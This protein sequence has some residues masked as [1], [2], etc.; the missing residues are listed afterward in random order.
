MG[1]SP[2][3]GWPRKDIRN[4]IMLNILYNGEVI[5][6]QITEEQS[7]VILVELAEKAYNGEIDEDK[8]DFQ[9]I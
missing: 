9:Y 6:K 2:N 7:L 5:H 3:Q 8:I 4:L 1:R